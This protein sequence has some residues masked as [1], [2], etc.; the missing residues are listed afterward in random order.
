MGTIEAVAKFFGFPE[1]GTRKSLALIDAEGKP[2]VAIVP[3]RPRAQRLQGR[4]RLWQGL[5]HDDRRG[6]SGERSA[7]RA[8]SDQLTCPRAF[9]WSADESLRESS[10][11][12]MAPTRSTITLP[13]PAPSATLPSTSGPTWSPSSPAT[14]PALRQ[15]ALRCPRHRGLSG[16]PAWHQVFRGHG[17]HLMDEGRQGEAAHHGLLRRGRVPFARCRRGAAQRRARYRLAGLRCPVRGR[18]DSA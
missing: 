13:V 6:A 15:A 4:A 2:V 9:V 7:Q 10:S 5:S 11:G 14:L 18:G 16:L 12:P 3:G 1:N 17:C 8:L